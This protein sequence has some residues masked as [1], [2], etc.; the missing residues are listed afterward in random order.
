M[1]LQNDGNQGAVQAPYAFPDI[2][3]VALPASLANQL[4]GKTVNLECAPVQKQKSMRMDHKGFMITK[5][6]ETGDPA[7]T[8][9][10]LADDPLYAISVNF[11]PDP[12]RYPTGETAYQWGDWTSWN[13]SNW[14][15]YVIGV[16]GCCCGGCGHAEYSGIWVCDWTINHWT[17]VSPKDLAAGVPAMFLTEAEPTATAGAPGRAPLLPSFAQALRGQAWVYDMHGRRVARGAVKNRQLRPGVY[18]VHAAAADARVSV[19][20]K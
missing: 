19:V 6:M 11:V 9:D 10:A 2:P 15:K 17:L 1:I 20:A 7:V 16:A 14:K 3:N 4:R 8:P 12:G 18:I 13:W 5:F